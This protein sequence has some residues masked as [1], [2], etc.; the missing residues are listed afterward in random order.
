MSK[1]FHTG[2]YRNKQSD[3]RDLVIK[4]SLQTIEN[5]YPDADYWVELATEEFSSICPK[6]GLP[7]FALLRIRYQPDKV[8]VEEKSL[9]LYLTAY[10]NL[11]IF[12]ENATNKI[13]EDFIAKIK[14]RKAVITADWNPRGGIGVKV[15]REFVCPERD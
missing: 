2:G 7:D 1:P 8:L 14:P 11:G 3:I 6:T 10:R 12:Q 4:P 13:F 15:E 5:I 9:K